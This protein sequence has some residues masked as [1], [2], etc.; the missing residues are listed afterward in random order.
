MAVLPAMSQTGGFSPYISV[1]GALT[2]NGHVPFW[3]RSDKYGSIPPAG[4]SGNVIVGFHK[5]YDSA[6]LRLFDWGSSFELRT[7]AG[8]T[9]HAELIEGYLKARLW[10]FEARAGRSKDFIGLVDSTLSSGSFAISGNAL[11]VPKVELAIRD[12]YV[13]PVLGGI[14]AVKGNFSYGWIGTVPVRDSNVRQ[15]NALLSTES[16]Y[17]R[18]G[19][20]DWRLKLHLGINHEIMWGDER[21]LNGR[22]YRLTPFQT[23]KY[24]V[25]GKTYAGSKVGNHLGSIDLGAEYETDGVRI[26]VYRQNFYDE[27][28]LYHLANIAD[29]LNGISITNKQDESAYHVR[30]RK[31]VAEFFYSK[32]QAGYPWSKRTAS[33]DENYYNNYQYTQGWSYKGLGMGNPFI[34]PYPSTRKGLVNDPTDYFNNNR[35][36]AFYLG[37]ELS[38][39]DM[40]ATTRL[41]Y[42]FNYGTF[43]TSQYGY[44][45]GNSFT[46][47]IYGL[48][49]TRKQFSAYLRL[50]KPLG[51]GLTA[52]FEGALDA[53]QLFDRSA[54]L[55]L[56]LSKTF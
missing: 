54:G 30:W 40:V 34:T 7:N 16:V 29:G 4:T 17:G 6:G 14:F 32:N 53:G 27:G 36:A 50:A 42:S 20:A 41:S 22:G 9:V 51:N 15:A 12:Y 52:G 18:F 31:F 37:A 43:G 45:T 19:K 1:G 10:I 47:P 11:G 55:T 3:L 35:V 24:V 49:Q 28:A 48:W 21:R 25:L 38:I 44:S 46:P 56:S 33:G 13:L 23:Y 8:S 26:M 39:D 5:K 2:T